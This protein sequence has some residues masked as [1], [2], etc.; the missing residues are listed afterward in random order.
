MSDRMKILS[1]ARLL[2][3]I[4]EEHRTHGSI[5][6]IPAEKFY[7][8]KG[9][10]SVVFHPTLFGKIMETPF[11][12][13]AGPHTQLSQN[14]ISA[15]LTGCRVIELKTVQEMDDLLIEKPC[16]DVF[17]EGYNT[18]WSQELTL[19]ESAEEYIR[20][21][22]LIHFLKEYLEL[23][24]SKDTSGVIFNMSVGYDLKGIQSEKMDRFIIRMLNPSQEI[25]TY[26]EMIQS[27]LPGRAP[28]PVPGDIVHSVTI[29]T[30]H[31]CPPEEIES[32]AC[33]LIREKGLHTYVKLNPT[34]LGK[35]EVKKILR[36][37][38]YGYISIKD[39]TFEKD[40][41]YD[42]AVKLIRN[43]QKF[44][45][46]H[47]KHFGIKLSNTLANKNISNVLPGEERYMSGRA[48]FP[49]T[50]NLAYRLASELDGKID[51][52][53]C[54]GASVLNVR[55]ILNTGIYPV[56][57]TTDALKPGGY[58]RFYQIA[59]ELEN[60]QV[61]SGTQ[62]AVPERVLVDRLGELALRSLQDEK[63]KKKSGKTRS[64]KVDSKLGFFDCIIAP[65]VTTCPIHQDIPDYIDF[66]RKGNYT[67]ALLTIL[68]KNPLPNITGY[69]C[70]HNCM[71][72]CVRLDYDNPVYIRD[73]KRIAAGSEDY[74][75]AI[76][77]L[78][79]ETASK[80]REGKA[81]VIGSGPAG[82]AAAFFLAREG[83]KVSMFEIRDRP[84]GTVRYAIPKF[85]LPDSVIDA[86]V[87]LLQELGVSIH[88]GWDCEYSVEELKKQ[89]F[90]YQ[91]I[92]TGASRAKKL[93]IGQ[94]EVQERYYLGIEFLERIKRGE[95]VSVGKKVLVI[96]GGNSAVDAARAA[97][98]FHPQWVHIVY[99]R[100]LEN[101]PADREEVEACFEEGIEIRE[102]LG[103]VSLITE[104]GLIRGL[105][106]VRMR[107]GAHDESGRR[108]PVPI[109]GSS[110]TLEADTVITA[111]GEEVDT[112]LLVR[113]GVELSER[114]TV[115]VDSEIGQT[116]I[117][118]VYAAGDCVRGPATVVEAIA[119]AKKIASAILQREH[120]WSLGALTD[121]YYTHVS[122]EKA[123]ECE[124]KH[125][126]V[127][128]FH[129][130]E[131]LPLEERGSFETV[132]K[133]LTEEK[134]R[135]ESERCLQCN[136]LCSRCVE[137]CP[138]RA[139]IAVSFQP[140]TLR[141]PVLLGPSGMARD[142]RYTV[143]EL[144]IEQATQILHIDD[145]CN[146]CGNCETF[147]PH[148]GAPYRDKLTL[149]S[150]KEGFESSDNSGFYLKSQTHKN[151]YIFNCRAGGMCF[152]LEV[153][154]GQKR[155]TYR[156]RQFN[157]VFDI[158]EKEEQPVLNNFSLS[159]V[160]TLD[161]ST[162]V[163]LYCMI[164]GLLKEYVYLFEQ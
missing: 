41:Q 121:S 92:T 85:R 134:A 88:T 150:E 107:L 62:S 99:R 79:K 163:A 54:G 119:D 104:N 145:F 50:I 58:L 69:I 158:R 124:S 91:I 31:G 138:N 135:E 122:A 38:G 7:R 73:L 127:T 24:R 45:E 105:K 3:W 46:S 15:Y 161:M 143:K 81:A 115:L 131:R 25:I 13:A 36:S 139:N 63:Y 8:P 106:C 128:V 1:F 83:F 72:T 67:N 10:E 151:S 14:I 152:D 84:G 153:D 142:N 114:N 20:S 148:M 144:R 18:E 77:K 37:G 155:L 2:S 5:F 96:G 39:G 126:I 113:N 90:D 4:L 47:G 29:S 162:M 160:D 74:G 71:S 98:R 65:C 19:Q 132:I 101:M 49:I 32:M 56:T 43:L 35:D 137:T 157:A 87:S 53:Y 156:S 42:D 116:N 164:D 68:K 112:E 51:I 55:D 9:K 102:L 80:Q 11:G 12:P 6:G 118:G 123:K 95:H 109:E 78:K 40:L 133:T 60:A 59:C 120:S 82:L 125:G 103:P 130:V 75:K 57:I 146:E 141:I 100:D 26:I 154:Y 33:Y 66:I 21:W 140:G 22:V 149:F 108:R 89:G 147:C 94:H 159:G 97:A 30:M 110:V 27:T 17:D 64:I 86:D 117:P 23:S 16:I 28:V 34:L 48:L 129:P 76:S 70:D 111:V 61:A 44:A 136:Q 52:S 93:D